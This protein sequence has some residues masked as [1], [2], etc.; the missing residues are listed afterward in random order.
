MN[1][2]D[3]QIER[4]IDIDADASRVW[5]LIS[6]PGWW[7]NEGTIV[8]RDFDPNADINV[9]HHVTYGAFRIQT[10]TLDSPRHAAFRWLGG[11]NDD[12]TSPNGGSTLVEFWIDDRDDRDGGVTLRVRESGFASLDVSDE[13]RRKNIDENTKGWEQELTAAKT[14]AQRP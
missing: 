13:A 10:V 7:I 2:T 5:E 4:Q 14:W 9:I 1:N 3:D 12:E 11:E 6:R 8:D